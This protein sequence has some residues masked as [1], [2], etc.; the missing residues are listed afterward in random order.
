VDKSWFST[1]LYTAH[2]QN[3]PG[4]YSQFFTS[5]PT[6]SRDSENTLKKLKKI[7]LKLTSAQKQK[8]KY[9][10]SVSRFVYNETI[11]YWQNPETRANWK[12]ST[13]F[14]PDKKWSHDIK[15]PNSSMIGI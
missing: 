2:N 7:Y 10:F 4:I 11:G 12:G 3:L 9:W 8:I 6:E 1:K 5:F 13:P 15:F 14:S